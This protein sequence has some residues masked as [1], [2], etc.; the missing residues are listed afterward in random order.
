MSNIQKLFSERIE[1]FGSVEFNKVSV[2]TGVI[3]IALK[4]CD[5]DFLVSSLNKILCISF[6]L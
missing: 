1:I 4:V 6:I 2:V 5:E 3:K